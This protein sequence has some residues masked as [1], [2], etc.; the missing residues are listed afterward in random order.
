[1][2][3][4]SSREDTLRQTIWNLLESLST[5]HT[6][7]LKQLF[8]TELNFGRANQPLST[9]DWPVS[10]QQ[11]LAGLP[12]LF[13]VAGEGDGFHVILLH[14]Q[15]DNL[16][17]KEERPIIAALLNDHPYALFIFSNAAQ[18]HW[19]FINVKLS[20]PSARGGTGAETARRTYRRIA[21]GPDDHLRTAVE[22][23][24]LLD[25][26]S[27]PRQFF[28]PPPLVIQQRCDEAFDVEKVTHAFFTDY[29]RIFEEAEASLPM[30]AGPGEGLTLEQRR[31][32]TQKFFNRLMFL[33]FLER[34]GWLL[35]HGQR[36]YLRALFSD[37]FQNEP[38]KRRT[39]NFHRTRLNTL[40]FLALNNPYGKD[41]LDSPDYQVFRALVGD[42]PYLNGGLFEKEVD[43]ETWFFPD[44]IVAKILYDLIYA[45]NF[46]I[47]ESTPLDVEVA[48]DPEML[49][50]MFEEL[51]TGRHE[52]GSYYTPKP[53][54]AFMCR[55]ALKGYLQNATRESE[56]AIARFVDSNDPLDL[57]DPEAMLSALK[58]VRVCDP[59]CGSGAYILGMLHELLEQR[60]CLFAARALDAKT[61]YERKLEIIQNNLYGVD[62]DPFAVNIARLRLWL[63]LVVDDTRSPL[64]DPTVDV[65]LPNLDF[66]IEAGDSLLSPDPS[67][68]LELGFRKQVVDDF[69]AL[70]Q[71]FL[72]EHDP[73]QKRALRQEI[74]KKRRLLAELAGRSAVEAGAGGA[75]FDWAVEFAEVFAAPSPPSNL[76][77][78][79]GGPGGG[80]DILLAN[81]PYVRQELISPLKPLLKRVYGSLYTGTADLY[82][83]FYL[84]A[85]Q[86][87]KPG[88]VACFIS[89]NKCPRAG[90]GETLRQHLLDAQ[91]FTLVVDFGSSPVF[92]SATAYPCIFLWKKQPRRSSSTLWATVTNLYDCYDEGIFEHVT[93]IG[94]ILP[95][96]QFGKGKERVSM[97]DKSIKV[98]HIAA[99]STPLNDYVNGKFYRGIV[100][101]LNEAFIINRDKHSELI[102]QDLTSK[103]LIKPLLRGDN[104]YRYEVQY[105]DEFYIYVEWGCP[106]ENYPA[107]FA[108]LSDFKDKLRQRPE[109]QQ[110]RF[111]WYAMSRYG[112]NFAHLYAMPKI[113]YPIISKQPNF[114]LDQCGFYG[115]DKTFFIAVSDWY[116]LGVLNSS[117]VQDWV[118][119]RFSPLRGGY[120]EFRG[121]SMENL[122]IPDAPHN[123]RQVVARLAEQAQS[124]HTQRRGRVETFLRQLGSDPAQSTSRNPLEQPWAL[125]AEEFTRRAKTLKVSETFRVLEVYE[126][127]RDE[128]AALTGQ[129]VQVEAEID[130]RV[131]E[132]YGV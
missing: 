5:Q 86:L 118:V 71:Q 104:V 116:L 17:T 52:S 33:A 130:A 62:L 12:L 100:S 79:G 99:S 103:D 35:F 60:A 16:L 93:R 91:A 110:G 123:E 24:A 85:H 56:A 48:V 90:Y 61:I 18:T 70:R 126:Q 40:F 13:A 38:A 8:W 19:H 39:A 84:R 41:R 20:F 120:F 64:A 30:A 10:L 23:L 87:L 117:S 7:A 2:K 95:A 107:I 109:V 43:D 128:T 54:V 114:V 83:Y 131:K 1:M 77:S 88:G 22:R 69:L 81:P 67:G 75:P 108:H 44:E 106:I 127:A 73:L 129:I 96:T 111:P 4:T 28:S 36:A 57:H 76:P 21:I 29:R 50:K 113:V 32:Y 11:S 25:I 3:Q 45:Y 72:T 122:P 58:R 46:T 112:A 15:A 80:F 89:S 119:K 34:K 14:L 65:S 6:Q 63:S 26:A 78:S 66:K 92:E 101:G 102:T 97:P 37:Y 53:V 105:R 115:N 98:G 42:A 68:G 94:Q 74:E 51:V 55:E 47:T 49:G 27:L 31:L 82:V 124:L 125:G 9:R 59:A 121:V 132:L